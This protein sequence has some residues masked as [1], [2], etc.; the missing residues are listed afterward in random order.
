[1]YMKED[2]YASA[3]HKADKIAF[4]RISNHRLTAVSPKLKSYTK[5]CSS[6]P[7]LLSICCRHQVPDHHVGAARLLVDRR[8]QRTSAHELDQL[9]RPSRDVVHP[10][11]PLQPP[12]DLV[13]QP[14]QRQEGVKRLH[15]FLCDQLLDIL[16]GHLLYCVPSRGHCAGRVLLDDLDRVRG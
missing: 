10:G 9:S 6:P 7:F 8:L 16:R 2:F 4:M 5:N 13:I 12:R 3:N 1:M 15:P 14:S 11:D